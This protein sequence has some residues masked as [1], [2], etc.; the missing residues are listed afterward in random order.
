[1]TR[2]LRDQLLFC[3][4]LAVVLIIIAIIREVTP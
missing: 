4:A 2:E 3:T 1:M